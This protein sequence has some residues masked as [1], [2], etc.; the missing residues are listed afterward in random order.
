[1]HDPLSGRLRGGMRRVL[2]SRRESGSE[3]RRKN[4]PHESIK[5]TNG[6]DL[7]K[8]NFRRLSRSLLI[9]GTGING[10]RFSPPPSPSPPTNP[11]GSI[12]SFNHWNFFPVRHGSLSLCYSGSSGSS[13][14][15]ETSLSSLSV[16]VPPLRLLKLRQQLCASTI[17][18]PYSARVKLNF[19]LS[20]SE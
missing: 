10:N 15:Q 3:I 9:K 19:L 7:D 11:R 16:V 14:T 5:R 6:H 12:D 18:C 8:K 13:E 1:M 2:F 20:R 17:S 4:C